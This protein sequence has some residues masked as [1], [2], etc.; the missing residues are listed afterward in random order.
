MKVLLQLFLGRPSAPDLRDGVALRLGGD[1]GPRFVLRPCLPMSV[2]IS[3][4]STVRGRVDTKRAC[5][6]RISWGTNRA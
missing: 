4:A 3:S 5:Y 2:S 1:R 6:A